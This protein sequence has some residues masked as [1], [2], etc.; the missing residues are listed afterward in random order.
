MFID[1]LNKIIDLTIK[2]KK[3]WISKIILFYF[4]LLY[5]KSKLLIFE[6]KQQ[7]IER[8][9]MSTTGLK[10]EVS[11]DILLVENKEMDASGILFVVS[12]FFE[13]VIFKE[14]I[15]KFCKEQQINIPTLYTICKVLQECV[16]FF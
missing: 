7:V 8:L 15:Q 16:F 2:W 11:T 6:K 3:K 13:W 5:Y 12:S 4:S 14:D 1:K 9:I 10:T